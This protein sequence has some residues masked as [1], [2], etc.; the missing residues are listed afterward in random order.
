VAF[1]GGD[2]A[3]LIRSAHAMT[4]ASANVG[5]SVLAGLCATLEADGLSGCLAEGQDQL[6]AVQ[7]EL[8]RVRLALNLRTRKS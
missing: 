6:D 4:G 1:A 2:D 7:S 5:A 8:G 3:E